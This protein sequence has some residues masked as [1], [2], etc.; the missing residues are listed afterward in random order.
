M[1]K[2]QMRCDVNISLRK[3]GELSYRPRVELK[4]M[5]SFSAVRRA[6]DHEVHRQ[7]EVY[8]LGNDVAQ[9]TRGWD[10]AT[11]TSC[12]MRSKE[13]AMDYRYIP[14]PDLPEIMLD[15]ERIQK[16]REMVVE[17]PYA[18]I[19]RYKEEYGFNKEYINGLINTLAMNT[20]FE[21]CVAG[22]YDPKLVA[23][24]LV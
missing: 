4:N 16:Q 21:L 9:E 23:T 2:G 10:D 5:S 22:G 8:A 24:W 20:Y 7:Q 17:S 3:V 6:I 14:E 12:M 13:D 1:E 11:T 18:R 15:A 19:Q